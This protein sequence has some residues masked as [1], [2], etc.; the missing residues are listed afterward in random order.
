MKEFTVDNAPLAYNY[1]KKEDLIPFIKDL[2]KVHF[3]SNEDLDQSIQ[4]FEK[5]IQ[6]LEKAKPFTAFDDQDQE[7]INDCKEATDY[8]MELKNGLENMQFSALEDG[9][10]FYALRSI[11][12]AGE[13]VWEL[14]QM[15]DLDNNYLKESQD[16]R[17]KIEKKC[18]WSFDDNNPFQYLTN[19]EELAGKKIQEKNN[20]IDEH[21]YFYNGFKSP[22]KIN[23]EDIIITS[24]HLGDVTDEILE[25]ISSHKQE[26]LKDWKDNQYLSNYGIWIAPDLKSLQE[27]NRSVGLDES[28]HLENFKGYGLFAPE[29]DIEYCDLTGQPFEHGA[30]YYYFQGYKINE[31]S[32]E[33]LI[34][35]NLQEHL[36][37]L[38]SN[39]YFYSE[40]EYDN[41]LVLNIE[42]IQ[43]YDKNNE[44][45][46]GLEEIK[47][48]FWS[49]IEK[50]ND[51]EL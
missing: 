19:Y 39:E 40:V 3:V 20:T 30:G 11:I 22:V 49:E 18:N 4:F 26:S 48:D 27:Y 44:L 42:N 16:L 37:D 23:L 10:S 15:Y 31:R 46:N 47:E 41:P 45:K 29:N 36:F 38:N 13:E 24:N 6:I 32:Y 21:V 14:V 34:D 7:R 5:G 33:Q 25:E 43:L 9:S 8:L 1:A 51:L 17:I 50:N 28:E 35:P 12:H 2:D